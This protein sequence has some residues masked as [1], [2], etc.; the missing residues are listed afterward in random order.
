[1]N[2]FKRLFGAN[3]RAAVDGWQFYAII[4][5][6]FVGAWFVTW[7]GAVPFPLFQYWFVKWDWSE[8]AKIPWMLLLLGP[9]LSLFFAIT[10][11]NTWMDNVEISDSFWANILTAVKAGIF[12]EILFRWLLFYMAMFTFALDQWL[13]DVLRG[14]PF[15]NGVLSLH[16]ILIVIIVVVG[17]FLGEIAVKIAVDRDFNR[18]VRFFGWAVWIAN[19]LLQIAVVIAL[20]KWAYL[21]ILF[22]I[23]NWVT[24]GHL[25]NIIYGMVWMIPAAMISTNWRFGSGH[26]LNGVI[27]GLSRSQ[28]KSPLF[29]LV[30][31]VFWGAFAVLH[32]WSLGMLFYWFMMHFGLPVAMAVHAAFDVVITMIVA[33][34]AEL[35]LF[36]E[37]RRRRR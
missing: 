34:D 37:S 6:A 5:S 32:T 17:W 3:I 35:E 19:K 33:L 21:S 14:I 26:L 25:E 16:W 10:S 18:V 29:T 31:V 15:I 9:T 2:I 11:K 22:P 36:F 24:L 13:L 8:F 23:V 20:L 7:I 4:A 30:S 12:E 28:N 27:G 1:V